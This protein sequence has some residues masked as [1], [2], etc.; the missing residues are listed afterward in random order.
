MVQKIFRIGQSNIGSEQAI[1]N[2]Q[3]S[4]VVT[5]SAEFNAKNAQVLPSRAVKS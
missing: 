1:F 5:Y 3:I 2:W 4:N